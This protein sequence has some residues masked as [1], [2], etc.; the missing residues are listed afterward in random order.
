MTLDDLEA[1]AAPVLLPMIGGDD[2]LG[3]HVQ[4]RLGDLG[5]L[6]P[7]PDGGF[8]PVSHWALRQF[9]GK[10]GMASKKQLDAEAARALL[11]ADADALYPVNPDGSLAGRI[12]RAMQAK[13]H[14]IQ[15]HP[16]ALNIVYVEGLD[17]D[18]RANDDAPNVFNDL[19]LLLRINTAGRPVIDASWEA[20]TEPGTYYTKVKKLDPQGAARIVLGQYKSWSVGTH[21]A[22]SPSRH[23]ALVQTAPI[24]VSRD[25]NEDFQR[26]GDKVFTGIF[27]VNQHWGFD[28]PKSDI[29][30][31]SAG[32]LVGRTKQGH[33]EFMQACKD[34]P[35]YVA[36]N[37]YRFMTTVLGARDLS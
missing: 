36:S 30:R 33:R 18:G 17:P 32:C 11:E 3:L 14:W 25:L 2:D 12:V 22:S 23:E 13:G 1:G 27:G 31:A 35:R 29:G 34:D 9:L 20:T 8:G 6:D 24:N 15:R 16:T 10:V 26:T 37:G 7:P 28:L 21:M 19:R 4:S 5:L